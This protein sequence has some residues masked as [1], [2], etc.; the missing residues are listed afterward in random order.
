M[1]IYRPLAIPAAILAVAACASVDVNATVP[2]YAVAV[3][4]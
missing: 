3:F 1:K 2:R 4:P